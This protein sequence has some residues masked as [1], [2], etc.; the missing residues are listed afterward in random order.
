MRMEASV[1]PLKNLLRVFLSFYYLSRPRASCQSFAFYPLM[2]KRK[3]TRTTRGTLF[4][5]YAPRVRQVRG[6][7]AD[8]RGGSRRADHP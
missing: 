1:R 3:R 4:L 7:D 5:A 2:K 8:R 6:R